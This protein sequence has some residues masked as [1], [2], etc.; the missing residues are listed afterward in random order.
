MNQ[1]AD[2]LLTDQS[3]QHPWTKIQDSIDQGSFLRNKVTE[4]HE[5]KK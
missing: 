4:G 1:S 2:H 5:I 3:S